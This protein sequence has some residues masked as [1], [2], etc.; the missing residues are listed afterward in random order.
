MNLL[1]DPPP[2]LA[3]E[4]ELSSSSCRKIDIYVHLAIPELWRYIRKQGVV[5]YQLQNGQYQISDYSLALPLV[6]ATQ[7]NQWVELTASEANDNA[8]IRQVRQWVQDQRS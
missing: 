6:S 1:N 7:L 4:I 5:I 3:I 8:I 2:D